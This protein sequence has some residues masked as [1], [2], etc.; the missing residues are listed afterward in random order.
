MNIRLFGVTIWSKVLVATLIVF[1]VLFYK[2][3][4]ELK[5]IFDQYP[6]ISIGWAGIV[7]ASITGFMVNDS[8]VVAAATC[9]IFLSFSLL[10]ILIQEPYNI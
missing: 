10:Y 4:G 8:G 6:Y 1:A 3:H 7:V 9:L 5:R 2:P